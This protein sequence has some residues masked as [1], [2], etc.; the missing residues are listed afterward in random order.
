MQ[1]MF[2]AGAQIVVPHSSFHRAL[3]SRGGAGQAFRFAKLMLLTGGNKGW[4]QIHTHLLELEEFNAEGWDECYLRI[5]DMLSLNPT[6]RGMWGGSWFYDPALEE[7]S[8]RLT[9]LRKVPQDNGAYVFFSNV[10]IDGGALA[11]SESRRKAYESGSYLPKSY[12]L[13]WP[14]QAMLDWA[15]K[16]RA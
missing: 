4:Y 10:D 12:S 9:Y 5:A 8:Q 7:V 3:F 15:K 2:P 11:T 14:R 13:I 16:Y 1:R 6:V